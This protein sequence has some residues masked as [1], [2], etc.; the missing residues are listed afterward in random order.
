MGRKA[1]VWWLVLCC[2]LLPLG[3]LAD[4]QGKDGQ[5]AKDLI[6]QGANLD[7]QGDHAGAIALFSKAIALG[8]EYDGTLERSFAYAASGHFA[9]AL[10]DLDRAQALQP[11]A[12]A[13][14]SARYWF[15]FQLDQ[16]AAVVATTDKLKSMSPPDPYA[17][18]LRFIAEARLGRDGTAELAKT[19]DDSNKDQWP[20]AAAQMF[21]GQVSPDQLLQWAEQSGNDQVACE[22]PFYVGEYFLIHQNRP[23]AQAAL[24]QNQQDL[25][26]SVLEY[27]AARSE[28]ASLNDSVQ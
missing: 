14:V 4:S 20:Q 3:A 10:Q 17:P 13:P 12:T 15:Q 11:K 27:Y 28:L 26:R 16:F 21:L 22:A 18:L 2:A 8:A 19:L 1:R 6:M 9:E 5:A 7:L 25:C 24:Q 23:Y